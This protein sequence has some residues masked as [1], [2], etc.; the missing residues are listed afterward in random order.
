MAANL[1]NKSRSQVLNG[2]K[3]FTRPR[4]I[5]HLAYDSVLCRRT[6]ME[7]EPLALDPLVVKELDKRDSAMAKANKRAGLPVRHAFMPAMP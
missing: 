4:L 7:G 1:S 6:F 5:Q 3:C 2:F